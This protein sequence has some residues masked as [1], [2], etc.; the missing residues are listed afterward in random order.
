MAIDLSG[1]VED[2]DVVGPFVERIMLRLRERH[3]GITP[4][5]VTILIEINPPGD[6][7]PAV[8]ATAANRIRRLL[9]DMEKEGV[10][11]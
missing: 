6:H 10:T 8:D 11:L 5:A 4:D 3:P 1:I 7:G 9:S 2:R